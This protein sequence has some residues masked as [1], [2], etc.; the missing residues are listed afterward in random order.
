MTIRVLMGLAVQ[1]FGF[2]DIIEVS[3]K[4]TGS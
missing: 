3:L 4:W 1:P 2:Y